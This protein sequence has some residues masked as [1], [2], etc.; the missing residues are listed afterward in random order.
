MDA[1]VEPHEAIHQRTEGACKVRNKYPGICY[2]CAKPVAVGEGHFERHAGGWRTQHVECCI[3]SRREAEQRKKRKEEE[4]ERKRDLEAR[5][6]R[7]MLTG[8]KA[9][10]PW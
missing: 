4:A 5:A 2:R 8:S 7:H 6:A 1:Q 9:W 3:L 10:G